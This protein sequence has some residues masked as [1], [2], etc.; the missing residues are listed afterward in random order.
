MFNVW[1]RFWN[2]S[3]PKMEPAH[4]AEWFLIGFGSALMRSKVQNIS[5]YLLEGTKLVHFVSCIPM[6]P[7]ASTAGLGR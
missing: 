3:G 5:G 4:W 7:S 6:C 2:H 1:V